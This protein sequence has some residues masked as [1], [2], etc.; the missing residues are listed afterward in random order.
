MK[1]YANKDTR[2]LNYGNDPI[3]KDITQAPS[4]DK[5]MDKRFFALDVKDIPGATYKNLK[6]RDKGKKKTNFYPQDQTH[7][8][9]NHY[10]NN[11]S[12]GQKNAVVHGIIKEQFKYNPVSVDPQR[13]IQTNEEPFIYPHKSAPEE[14][15]YLLK[16]H[17]RQSQNRQESFE[18]EMAKRK[19]DLDE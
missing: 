3:D 6:Y 15:V 10:Y 14:R 11:E 5:I 2:Y 13:L 12:L 18:I 19:K 8:L 17:L 1:K 4:S 16:N 7:G 9:M